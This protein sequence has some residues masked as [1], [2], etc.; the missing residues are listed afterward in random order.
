MRYIP[1]NYTPLIEERPLRVDKRHTMLPLVF[2][3]LGRIPLKAWH[4]GGTLA[5]I[6]Q[7]RHTLVWL[8]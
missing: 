8:H 2:R 5:D 4:H 7:S 6:W 3:I 1:R